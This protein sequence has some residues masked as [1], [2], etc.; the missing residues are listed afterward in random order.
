MIDEILK[1]FPEMIKAM[2]E[3]AEKTEVSESPER[4]KAKDKL[5]AQLKGISEDLERLSN[6]DGE[7]FTEE[8]MKELVNIPRQAPNIIPPSLRGNKK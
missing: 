5:I 6:Q 2:L 1:K 3:K 4:K 8:Q 7:M